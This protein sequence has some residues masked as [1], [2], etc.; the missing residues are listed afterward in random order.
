MNVK[1]VRGIAKERGLKNF[2]K[3]TKTDLIHAIQ[4]AEGNFD[5]YA[6]DPSSCGQDDCMWRD[7]CM[8]AVKK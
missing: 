6:T 7:D 5:C 3:L 1:E 2:S 4:K 8:N